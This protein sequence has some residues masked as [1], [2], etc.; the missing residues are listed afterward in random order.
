MPIPFLQYSPVPGPLCSCLLALKLFWSGLNLT[1]T[2]C[3]NWCLSSVCEFLCLNEYGKINSFSCSTITSCFLYTSLRDWD[4]D[5]G[6]ED[7]I[8]LSQKW[9]RSSK[10][11][12]PVILE[13]IDYLILN[14]VMKEAFLHFLFPQVGFSYFVSPIFGV[15]FLCTLTIISLSLIWVLV[16]GLLFC[17]HTH[18]GGNLFECLPQGL[19][20]TVEMQFYF[21]FLLSIVFSLQ[22]KSYLK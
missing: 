9:H 10:G 13:V 21:P 2:F 3:Q 17:F 1:E 7:L 11:R 14:I 16:W 8:C 6:D 5:W 20:A 22:Q 4:W 19:L 18:S 15:N 12:G